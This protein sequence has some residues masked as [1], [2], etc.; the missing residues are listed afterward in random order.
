MRTF[1]VSPEALIC[2]LAA[3]ENSKFLTQLQLSLSKP[4]TTRRTVGGCIKL[5]IGTS[6]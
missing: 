4:L 2:L 6:V 1:K 3:P 5:L